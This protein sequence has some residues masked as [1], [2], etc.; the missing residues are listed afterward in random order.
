MCTHKAQH[1]V[2]M[3]AEVMTPPLNPC[4]VKGQAKH[5]M[6]PHFCLISLQKKNRVN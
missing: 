2:I 5:K 3:P 4:Q 1:L 6:K